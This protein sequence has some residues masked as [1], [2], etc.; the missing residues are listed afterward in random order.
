MPQFESR[1]QRSS[2]EEAAK[3]PVRT[4]YPSG[5]LGER[6]RRTALREANER[7][8]GIEAELGRETS[9]ASRGELIRDLAGFLSHP[10]TLVCEQAL[11][12]LSELGTE[13]A[14]VLKRKV[15]SGAPTEG[16]LYALGVLARAPSC[17]E[18][19]FE[20]LCPDLLRLVESDGTTGTVRAAAFALARFLPQR[21]LAAFCRNLPAMSPEKAGP[22]LQVMADALP[23]K[24]ADLICAGYACGPEPPKELALLLGPRW[25]A[26]NVTSAPG[27]RLAVTFGY[28]DEETSNAWDGLPRDA[29]DVACELIAT[30]GLTDMATVEAF[31]ASPDRPAL[32]ERWLS[33]CSQFVRALV[34]RDVTERR[35]TPGLLDGDSGEAQV[36]RLLVF[37]SLRQSDRANFEAWSST[38]IFSYDRLHCR[39]SAFL[40]MGQAEFIREVLPLWRLRLGSLMSEAPPG[41]REVLV[42]HA[43]LEYAAVRADLRLYDGKLLEVELHGALA[44]L[45]R[46]LRREGGR[47]EVDGVS[48]AA[49]CAMTG[50]A[51]PDAADLDDPQGPGRLTAAWCGAA[52]T[53][54]QVLTIAE[55]AA[56][57]EWRR[58][59]AHVGKSL[60]GLSSGTRAALLARALA[61]CEASAA[62]GPSAIEAWLDEV[63]ASE[64]AERA[65]LERAEPLV[66]VGLELQC[67]QIPPAARTAWREAAR[68]LQCGARRR[69]DFFAVAEA[70]VPPSLLPW[71]VSQAA[72]ELIRRAGATPRDWTFHLSFGAELGDAAAPLGMALLLMSDLDLRGFAPGIAWR[73]SLGSLMSKGLVNRNFSSTPPLAGAEAPPYHTEFRGLLLRDGMH[74]AVGP[75]LTAIVSGVH[76][77]ASVAARSPSEL[78]ATDGN[79]WTQFSAVLSRECTQF[80]AS[81]TALLSEPLAWYQSTGDYFDRRLVADLPVV[82]MLEALFSAAADRPAAFEG[83]RRNVTSLV[84]RGAPADG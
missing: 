64:A 62:T 79:P 22:C 6:P 5:F 57:I 7:L 83:L 76:R 10:N 1:P 53:P 51:L 82:G 63:D 29:Q 24:L 81:A 14:L 49:A 40:Q 61:A 4:T 36:D 30:L 45:G 13:G 12:V 15:R 35:E 39:P 16:E 37:A 84:V 78:P 27:R 17:R 8:G 52:S 65:V 80:D 58:F 33:R 71:A 38:P 67:T 11:E 46:V 42:N 44:L 77:L 25:V 32:L 66:S 18:V 3:A 73:G 19:R 2:R 9:P 56:W 69:P 41:A 20:E 43:L 75:R 55:P 74:G 47:L 60:Q 54:A 59:T 70:A 68:L 21:D 28:I 31:R 48:H 72:D 34:P 23:E 26:R 50:E